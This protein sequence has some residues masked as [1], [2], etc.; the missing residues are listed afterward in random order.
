MTRIFDEDL[1]AGM[2]TRAIHAGQ[3]PEPLAPA[4]S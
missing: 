4:L 1:N 3:R 2:F